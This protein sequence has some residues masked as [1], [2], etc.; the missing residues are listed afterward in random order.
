MGELGDTYSVAA[1]KLSL[2]GFGTAAKATNKLN[3]ELL[4]MWDSLCEDPAK[5]VNEDKSTKAYE[6]ALA[7]LHQAVEDLA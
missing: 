5:V 4:A 7:A 3:T 1:T 6:A 2:Y